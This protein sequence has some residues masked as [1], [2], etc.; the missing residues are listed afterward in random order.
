MSGVQGWVIT[1]KNYFCMPSPVDIP[2]AL[3]RGCSFLLG[4]AKQRISINC[5]MQ[6]L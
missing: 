5:L 6:M 4:K 2:V 3:P 1:E